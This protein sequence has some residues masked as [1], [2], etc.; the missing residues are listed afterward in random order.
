MCIDYRVDPMPNLDEEKSYDISQ[1]P[2]QS[3]YD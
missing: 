3:P 2:S 1:G